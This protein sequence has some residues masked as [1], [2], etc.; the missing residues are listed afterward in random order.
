MGILLIILYIIVGIIA[1]VLIAALFTKKTY[2]VQKSVT[3]SKPREQVFN[4]IKYINNQQHYNKWVMA[5][6][7]V[8]QEHRGIDG[9]VGYTSAWE[10]QI[11]QV[12]KGEQQ[13]KALVEGKRIDLALHFIKPSEGRAE[14]FMETES[15]PGNQTKLTWGLNGAMKYPVNF[16]MLVLIKIPDM[17]GK[18]MAISLSNLKAL[19]EKE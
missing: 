9:T 17:L 10:S 6:P 11:K 14:A 5:D 16:I 7:N 1:L 2:S 8:K 13:I 19:L 4:Y 12:G 18:D 15:L 3:I